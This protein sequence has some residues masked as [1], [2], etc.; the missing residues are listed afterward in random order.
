M[1]LLYQTMTTDERGTMIESGMADE[2]EMEKSGL[3]R[4][5]KA[6]LYFQLMHVIA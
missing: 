3:F 5:H 2:T 1:G 4:V 6:K